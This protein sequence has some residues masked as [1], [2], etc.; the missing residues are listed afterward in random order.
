MQ[1]FRQLKVWQKAHALTMDIY[2]VTKDFP[3]D[4]IYGLRS[5][6]RRAS[7]S[8]PTNIV[9]GVSRQTDRSTRGFLDIAMGSAGEVEYLLILT[10]ALGLIPTAI[11]DSSL[12]P[13]IQEI[14]RMLNGFIKRLT[15]AADSRRRGIKS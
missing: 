7:A 10:T 14:R 3:K 12:T 11:S 13:Q 5:Q 8:V 6:L 2:K 1:D 9:E 15:S 4:E